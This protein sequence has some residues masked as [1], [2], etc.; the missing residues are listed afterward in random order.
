MKS[1]ESLFKLWKTFPEEWE[2]FIKDWATFSEVTIDVNQEDLRKSIILTL[3][4]SG[5]A[6]HNLLKNELLH[7]TDEECVSMNTREQ[8]LF[9]FS[10]QDRVNLLIDPLGKLK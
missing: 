1:C 6:K 5:L 7:F 2:S 3:R 8:Q 10:F 4:T 9:W